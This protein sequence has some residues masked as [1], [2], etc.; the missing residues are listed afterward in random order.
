MLN[1]SINDTATSDSFVEF[2]TLTAKKVALNPTSPELDSLFRA[3]IESCIAKG[4]Y[5]LA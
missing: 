3:L 1:R 2:I 4:Q 5:D